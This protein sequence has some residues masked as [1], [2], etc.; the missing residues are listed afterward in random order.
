MKITLLLA[1]FTSPLWAFKTDRRGITIKIAAVFHML[2][3]A[4]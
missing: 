3:H 2:Q 1:Y 4:G